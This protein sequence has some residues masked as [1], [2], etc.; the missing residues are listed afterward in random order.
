MRAW[1]CLVLA[2]A[3]VDGYIVSG[4]SSGANVAINTLFAF[5]CPAD[6]EVPRPGLNRTCA[7]G[8][9]AL[10]GSPYGCNI[11]PDSGATGKGNVCGTPPKNENWTAHNIRF[12]KYIEGREKAGLIAPLSSLRGKPVFLY[13]GL[14]D[15]IVNQVQ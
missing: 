9:M 15:S 3:P 6:A 11:L 12:L 4:F 1:L 5:G 8:M 14:H 10:G 13:S 2:A 7:E